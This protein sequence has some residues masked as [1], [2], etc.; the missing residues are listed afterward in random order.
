MKFSLKNYYHPTPKFFRKL[1]DAILYG[2]GSIGAT[3]LIA[4]DE[5]KELFAAHELKI[6]IGAVLI[7]GFLGKF[8]TNFFKDEAQ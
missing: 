2:C 3:G 6:I 5:L 8:L 4:F 1:G 7:L